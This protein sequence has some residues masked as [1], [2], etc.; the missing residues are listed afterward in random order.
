[1]SMNVAVIE[2]EPRPGKKGK[3]Y[4]IHVYSKASYRT[5]KTGEPGIISYDK[6]PRRYTCYTQK[7]IRSFMRGRGLDLIILKNVEL[8]EETKRELDPCLI[9]SNGKYVEVPA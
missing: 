7:G 9:H 8:T 4:T 2:G 6:T 5:A 3:M 1:M